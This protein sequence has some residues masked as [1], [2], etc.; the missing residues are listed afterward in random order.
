MRT[1]V[2]SLILIAGLHGVTHA[3]GAAAEANR[4]SLGLYGCSATGITSNGDSSVLLASCLGPH[5]IYASGDFGTTW[6]FAAGGEYLSGSVQGVAVA[7]SNA[8]AL[9]ATGEV[10]RS[11]LGGAPGSFSWSAVPVLEAEIKPQ[12]GIQA[13]DSFVFAGATSGSQPAVVALRAADGSVAAISAIAQPDLV[14]LSIAVA[15]DKAYAVVGTFP[16]STVRKLYRA[17][18]DGGTGVMSDWEDITATVM[19]GAVGSITG[20]MVH[21][22]N[23]GPSSKLFVRVVGDGALNQVYV[24]ANGGASFSLAIPVSIPAY[25]NPWYYAPRD[26]L[27]SSR[28]CGKGDKVILDQFVSLD[29]G[30]SWAKFM[31]SVS[32]GFNLFN[33]S[34]CVF[35]QSDAA[36]ERA[37]VRAVDGF[38]L[39]VNAGAGA[40]MSL[41]H[42]TAGIEGIVVKGLTRATADADRVALVTNAGIGI[43]TNF[44]QADRRWLFPLCNARK[45]C[46]G[47]AIELDRNDPSVVYS[48]TENIDK[49]VISHDASG[50]PTVSWSTLTANPRDNGWDALLFRTSTAFPGEVFAVFRSFYDPPGQPEKRRKLGGIYVYGSAGGN[51]LRTGLPDQPVHDLL[52]I[53][54]AAM[55]A[56]VDYVPSNPETD[57]RGLYFSQDGGATWSKVWAG[58]VSKLAYDR[59]RDILYADGPETFYRLAGAAAGTGT[60]VRA[61]EVP[62]YPPAISVDEAT[63]DVFISWG[64][65]VWRST[66]QGATWNKYHVGLTDESFLAL[67]VVPNA[68]PSELQAQAGPGSVVSGSNVGF[69]KLRYKPVQFYDDFR[70]GTTAGDPEWRKNAG[71]WRVDARKRY[72]TTSRVTNLS[73]VRPAVLP[74]L[75]TGRVESLVTMSPGGLATPNAM[76]VF[77]FQGNRKYRYARLT[78]GEIQLGQVGLFGGNGTRVYARRT[79]AALVG[80]TYRLRVDTYADGWVK[81]YLNGARQLSYRFKKPMLG[82]VGVGAVKAGA[83]FD[84]FKVQDAT[85]LP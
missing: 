41:S 63:G 11:S 10:L 35:D 19:A 73:T 24:S 81:V 28:L 55:Y 61:G 7:G 8:F 77:G 78:N 31:P 60:L 12:A 20:A 46:W 14:P 34:L 18:Y 32:E 29:G 16:G 50:K 83:I 54:A 27:V 42:A 33:S 5:G 53:G 9:L 23:V 82:A 74:P 44:T 30:A 38:A 84:N 59:S 21:D 1:K 65:V 71:L 57:T 62:G 56:T 22:V 68:A 70:N 58:R 64:N 40:S 6:V 3:P 76:I 49:G 39:T 69:N 25:P 80:G 17:A 51:L 75:A 72:Q 4:Q 47:S 15:A 37:L 79:R 26:Y 45:S 48:G 52:I 13:A 66:D 36:S 67:D 43:T 2:L 85:V